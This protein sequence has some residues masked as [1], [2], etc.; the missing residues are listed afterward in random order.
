MT[1]NY[2]QFDLIEEIT[3]NDG[4][5]YFEIANIDQNGIAELAVDRHEIAGVRIL[6]LNIARTSALTTYEQYINEHYELATLTNEADWQNPQ[7]VEWDKPKG[8]VFDAY[9]F[10]LKS[11]RIG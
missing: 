5:R 4:T 11:N 8:K 7:W 10:V 2:Q 9:Q 6:Q 1:R 3:R